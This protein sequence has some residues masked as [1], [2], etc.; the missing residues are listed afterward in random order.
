MGIR[1]QQKETCDQCREAFYWTVV[2][3]GISEIIA[4]AATLSTSE[5]KVQCPHCA[6][7]KTVNIFVAAATAGIH[8][9][10]A[11]ECYSEQLHG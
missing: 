9:Q 3:E 6:I 4:F 7:Q 8:A 1:I 10:F 5:I 11:D 2:P